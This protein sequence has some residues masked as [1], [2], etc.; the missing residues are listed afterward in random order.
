MA[1]RNHS[2]RFDARLAL[3][4]VG[5]LTL[6][7]ASGTADAATK[8]SRKRPQTSTSKS[9]GPSKD[10]PA[11]QQAAPQP[12]G[13]Q[14]PSS[15]PQGGNQ[16][17]NNGGVV[18]Q[19][20]GPSQ[21]GPSQGGPVQGAPAQGSAQPGQSRSA[22][23]GAQGGRTGVQGQVGPQSPQRGGPAMDRP[24]T[25]MGG[26]TPGNNPSSANARTAPDRSSSS[27]GRQAT[28]STDT[29]ART[30]PDRGHSSGS[31]GSSSATRA[32]DSHGGSPQ[33]ATRSYDSR[34]GQHQRPAYQTQ[35][36]RYAHPSPHY[37]TRP[38]PGA[39]HGPPP[40][41]YYRASYVN[42]WVHPYYRYQ[43]TATVVVSFGFV[44][45]PWV[46]TW[47][48]PPRAGW[49]WVG[50]YYDAW[51][52]YHPG[53]W[54]PAAPPVRYV[55]AGYVYVPGWWQN[56]VYIEGYYRAPERRGWS[57]VDGY[58]LSDG[59]YVPGHW[60]PQS[61]APEGYIWEPGFFDGDTWVEGF[62]RPEH[63]SGYTWVNGY[64]DESG[65]FSAGYWMPTTSN[66]G[67]VWV[68]GWFDGQAWVEG[69][70]EPEAKYYS[71]DVQNWQPEQG[72]NDG[73]DSSSSASDG[74]KAAVAPTSSTDS[75]EE[76]M[77]LAV[78]VEMEE[79]AR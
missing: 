66:P 63:R 4:L 62:Y 13:Q 69:Y 74:K 24:N 34:A 17:G 48:P 46:V 21:G 47:A 50:G 16:P 68:P 15:P 65:V 7:S 31:G 57:W 56:D 78:P 60:Q 29:R 19:A 30:P 64:F 54:A 10:A 6:L 53:Y 37:H 26:M 11:A 71:A 27:G 25:N 1:L 44:V 38:Y 72:W 67:Y 49:S 8:N 39:Q 9:S 77:P 55:S 28:A 5:I 35:D 20:G 75:A 23:P 41:A 36:H 58:Y 2:N 40:R 73:W 18:P 33:G 51:G 3:G 79:E 43:H 45:N 59:A 61:S 76:D 42:W 14:Q 70:W 22:D 52:F 12:A 32:H